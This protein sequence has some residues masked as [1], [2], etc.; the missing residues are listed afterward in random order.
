MKCKE[1]EGI[2]RVGRDVFLHDSP[3]GFPGELQIMCLELGFLPRFIVAEA[4]Y[5]V[6]PTSQG[7]SINSWKQAELVI[8]LDELCAYG[9][10][11]GIPHQQPTGYLLAC[12]DTWICSPHNIPL[13]QTVPGG[14]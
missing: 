13:E 5:H 11:H 2:P 10:N 8:E 14:D 4:R 3:Q 7:T 6:R 12:R 9:L 1:A